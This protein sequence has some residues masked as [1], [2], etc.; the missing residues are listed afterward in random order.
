VK[1]KINKKLFDWDAHSSAINETW[2]AEH[3]TIMGTLE[4]KWRHFAEE[5]LESDTGKGFQIVFDASKYVPSVLSSDPDCRASKARKDE[6]D[7]SCLESYEYRAPRAEPKSY[8][9][10]PWGINQI[11]RNGRFCL[12]HDSGS[13]RARYVLFTCAS[14]DET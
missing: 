3:E 9:G 7:A 2:K 11:F 12:C 4:K 5:W 14:I 1:T 13:R 10:I 8:K 6:L